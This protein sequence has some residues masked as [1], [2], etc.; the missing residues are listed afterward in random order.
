MTPIFLPF[1]TETTGFPSSKRA[2]NDPTQ[3]HIVSCSALQVL[4]TGRI[5]QSM[6]KMVA[7]AG[8]IW[9]M[10]SSA[11]KVH[12]LTPEE[13]V[14]YGDSEKAILDEFLHLWHID[15][16][17]I[18]HQLRFDRSI[19]AV[20]IARYYPKEHALLA[21][22]QA[23]PGTCTQTENK[24]RVGATTAKGAKKAPNLAET[25]KFF[26]GE[27]LE[28]HHSA[29]ADAVAVYTIWMHMQRRAS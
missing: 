24:E 27:N 4:P 14:A 28:R 1:D 6:S 26:T 19:I 29:N 25:Y 10:E 9:D 23:A 11:A 22:W 13:C 2:L 20:A 3:P 18:A 8:W 15:A 17:L 16:H 7:P 21:A 5:Q 12:G